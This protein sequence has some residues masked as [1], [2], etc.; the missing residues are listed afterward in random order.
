MSFKDHF[1]RLAAQYS[2]YRPSYPASLF[3]YLAQCCPEHQVVWDCACGNGQATLG[4]AEQFDR[5]IAT[6]ASPQQ[7]AA[8]PSRDN[9][10]YRVARAED[11][12]IEPSSLDL[13]TVAQALHWFNLDDFYRE[14]TRV[15][16]PSGILAVWTYGVI[17]V[18]DAPA[19]ALI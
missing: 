8:A 14:V 13:V 11:S 3:A 18:D 9:V 16:K 6:D 12:G 17:H 4:L 7:V 15:L 10:T 1:S 2:A 19:D 5:V